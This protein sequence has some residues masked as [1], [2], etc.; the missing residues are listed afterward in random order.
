VLARLGRRAIA[1]DEALHPEVPAN[2]A[3]QAW[4]G[5]TARGRALAAG[6]DCV[7]SAPYYLDLFFPADLHYRADPAAP[8]AELLAAEDALPADPRLAHVAEGLA[9]TR[10]WRDD[11]T[12]HVTD[13][14]PGRLLGAEACLW[15]EL[16]DARLLD[17]RLWSRMPALAER[18]WSPADCRDNACMYQRLEAVLERLPRWAGVD[19]QGDYRR[20][21]AEA[22][23]GEDWRPLADLL[24]PVKWYARLLGQEALAARLGGREMPQARPYHADSPLDRVVDALPPE[25]FATRKLTALTQAEAEGDDTARAGLR[26]QAQSWKDLP[27]GGGPAEL[28]PAAERL[29]RLGHLVLAVL[30][31]ELPMVEARQQIADAAEPVGE[32]FLA[33]ALVLQRWLERRVAADPR[34]D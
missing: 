11:R 13:E 1:W 8:D 19:V 15:A 7:V 23:L 20:L 24:E 14:P 22:K 30:D 5:A 16:V 31:G 34:D 26:V 3:V 29:R 17:V 12:P 25:S 32:Y 21:T 2:V 33:P 4:R 6:H 10:Q 27:E 18:F 28:E 9:W